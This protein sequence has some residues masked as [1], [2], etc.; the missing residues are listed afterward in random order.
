MI[1]TLLVS[2]VSDFTWWYVLFMSQSVNISGT[3][4][5]NRGIYLEL[6][7]SINI[8]SY[9]AQWK[10]FSNSSIVLKSLSRVTDWKWNLT[11]QKFESWK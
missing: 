7:Q 4:R 10:S 1:L 2:R 8:V 11:N 3:V 9:T 5:F 6:I